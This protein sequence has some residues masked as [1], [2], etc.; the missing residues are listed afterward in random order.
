MTCQATITLTGEWAAPGGMGGMG[1]S[2]DAPQDHDADQTVINSYVDEL[3]A[4]T[5]LVVVD[6]QS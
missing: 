5:L 4:D 2:T 1:V 6:C 3:P